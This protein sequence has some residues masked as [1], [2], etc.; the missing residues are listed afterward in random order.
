MILTIDAANMLKR[1][2]NG[3]VENLRRLKDDAEAGLFVPL[4]KKL[5]EF[6]LFK[7]LRVDEFEIRHSNVLAWLLDPSQNHMLGNAFLRGFL[8]EVAMAMRK[9]TSHDKPIFPKINWSRDLKWNVLREVEYRDIQF[10]CEELRLVV[11]VENKWNAKE[12]EGSEEKDGQLTRYSEAVR[13]SYGGWTKLFVFLTPFGGLPSEKN[14]DDWISLDYASV[15]KVLDSVKF[16]DGNA[17]PSP[18][19][20]FIEQYRQILRKKVCM[21]S[22]EMKLGME[23]YS[24]HQK[25]IKSIVDT[26][27]EVK[28]LVFRHFDKQIKL[29]Q[30][31]LKRENNNSRRY[32]QF[33][34][35]FPCGVTNSVHY[36]IVENETDITVSLH[37]ESGTKKECRD[38]IAAKIRAACIKKSDIKAKKYAFDSG[39]K[40]I[41]VVDQSVDEV[42]AEVIRRFERL[43]SLCEP[44][45]QELDKEF[46]TTVK[47]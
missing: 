32:Y 3:V 23:I 28:E 43:Y 42:V 40:A 30:G 35:R 25:A 26:L 34:Q 13:A 39:R 10:E 21:D 19:R 1:K 33:K 27:S 44:V 6:N 45:L 11:C 41:S 20:M 18:Q 24:K 8:D 46:R 2:T 5:N 37:V 36:E 17:V 16:E 38:R 14:Q 7:V 47:N 4:E 22:E 29:S 15:L 9:S 31:T 12:N